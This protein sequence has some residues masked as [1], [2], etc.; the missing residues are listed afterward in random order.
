MQDDHDDATISAR[1]RIAA[2]EAV[3]KRKEPT[4]ERQRQ[5]ARFDERLAKFE[6]LQ[7]ADGASS[8]QNNGKAVASRKHFFETAQKT[9]DLERE[10]SARKE[11]F[12]RRRASFDQ[13]AGAQPKARRDRLTSV[14]TIEA[15]NNL[16]IDEQG[17]DECAQDSGPSVEETLNS[18][19]D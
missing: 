11:A 1:D 15:I 17:A 18:P 9:E 12:E 2:F 8:K 7:S 16:R 13:T 14:G 19:Q 4:A 5:R 10:Q 6:R 3:G